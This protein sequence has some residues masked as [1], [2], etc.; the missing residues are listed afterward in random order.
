[1]TFSLK[2]RQ[3]SPRQAE[4]PARS[5]VFGES[6]Q[7]GLVDLYFYFLFEYMNQLSAWMK[8]KHFLTNATINQWRFLFKQRMLSIHTSIQ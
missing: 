3:S 4:T 8:L 5:F 2:D 7:L 6:V 1:M